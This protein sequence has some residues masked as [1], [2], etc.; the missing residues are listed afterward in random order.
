MPCIMG[1]P[2]AGVVTVLSVTDVG[3][4]ACAHG[5]TKL[6]AQ[7]INCF[8]NSS[9]F[10]LPHVICKAKIVMHLAIMRI[11]DISVIYEIKRHAI[12]LSISCVC[13]YANNNLLKGRASAAY[14]RAI[15]DLECTSYDMWHTLLRDVLVRYIKLLTNPEG[16]APSAP[17]LTRKE[18][19]EHDTTRKAAAPQPPPQQQP[20]QPPC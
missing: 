16:P 7:V 6:I 9:P 15:S 17:T 5:R 19:I 11:S 4:P 1:W 10:V 3:K 20:Q 2:A 13:F 18:T 14:E 12:S 8:G